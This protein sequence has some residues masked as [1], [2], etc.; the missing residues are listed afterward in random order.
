MIF[1]DLDEIILNIYLAAKG[2]FLIQKNKTQNKE[3]LT[4]YQINHIKNTIC[5]QKKSKAQDHNEIIDRYSAGQNM[6]E[7]ELQ[8]LMYHNMERI[9]VFAVN[10]ID[11]I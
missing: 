5:I 10:F 7:K 11:A 3:N 1:P 6:S 9:Q 4:S 2:K 8:K